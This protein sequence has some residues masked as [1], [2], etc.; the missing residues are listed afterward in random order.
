MP[1]RTLHLYSHRAGGEG[2]DLVALHLISILSSRNRRLVPSSSVSRPGKAQSKTS[3]PPRTPQGASGAPQHRCSSPRAPASQGQEGDPRPR[4]QANAWGLTWVRPS[5]KHPP[6]VVGG[7]RWEKFNLSV[8]GVSGCDDGDR[9]V[10]ILEK[11][12]GSPT[13]LPGFVSTACDLP[14]ALPSSDCDYGWLPSGS[15]TQTSSSLR[16]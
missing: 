16:F 5:C 1:A 6:G 13:L 8:N 10:I 14:L 3:I 11:K 12:A 4:S 2:H 9:A 15:R 7:S